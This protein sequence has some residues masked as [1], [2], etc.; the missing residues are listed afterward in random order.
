L[1][2][3]LNPA[4]DTGASNQ[5][6]ITSVTTPNFTGTSNPGAAVTV[7]AQP[8]VGGAPTPIAQTT[9]NNFGIWSANSA[10]LG[11]GSYIITAKATNSF[12]Q[13]AS[14]TILPSSRPLVI[15]NTAPTVGTVVYNRTLGQVDITLQDTR[16]G[17]NVG[18]VLNAAE[19]SFTN[20]AKRNSP[21]LVTAV[22]AQPT[23]SGAT[24][25]MVVL[26]IKGGK[27]IKTGTY[28]LSVLAGIQDVA[29]NATGHSSV[30]SVKPG[31][32]LVTPAL[33]KPAAKALAVHDAALSALH[34][35]AVHHRRFK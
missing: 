23:S 7:F 11:A 10:A 1:T 2:G 17:F 29:G 30:F 13:S 35:S 14:V 20:A 12:G 28:S 15:A 18:S 3:Q 31:K 16:A 19:Y 27:K 8:T 6:A 33:A 24:T 22:T 4:S 25:E 21:N 32:S 34:A 26:T 9:T 5:D